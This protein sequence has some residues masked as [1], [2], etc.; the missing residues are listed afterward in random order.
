MVRSAP[1]RIGCHTL[2]KIGSKKSVDYDL[3]ICTYRPDRAL[4]PWAF[5]CVK[6]FYICRET[7]EAFESMPGSYPNHDDRRPEPVRNIVELLP[8]DLEE[9]P[10]PEPVRNIVELL[11]EDLEEIP[12]IMPFGWLTDAAVDVNDKQKF[13]GPV[14]IID[15][16]RF[17]LKPFPLTKTQYR[18]VARTLVNRVK[19]HPDQN[20]PSLQQLLG[21]RL[22]HLYWSRLMR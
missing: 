13:A 2:K 12:V 6:L 17:N 11:P 7:G 9:I 15:D 14:P 21:D 4:N 10:E 20:W 1:K 19:A 22:K 16:P 18:K 3:Y 5:W 8:E